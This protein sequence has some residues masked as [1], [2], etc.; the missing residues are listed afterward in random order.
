PTGKS[1]GKKRGP[2]HRTTRRV[3][4]SMIP[5]T[6]VV[7][8]YPLQRSVRQCYRAVKYAGSVELSHGLKSNPMPK[9]NLSGSNR[10][11]QIA[12]RLFRE[13]LISE[14]FKS[15]CRVWILLDYKPNNNSDGSAL[16]T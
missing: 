7:R 12:R 16:L 15:A 13:S 1:K 10:S 5:G 11:L 9:P 14:L 6:R 8:P 3:L 2:N 4:V